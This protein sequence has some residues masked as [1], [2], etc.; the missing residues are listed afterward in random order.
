MN[1][2][3]L[4]VIKVKCMLS[5]V[6]FP[7][8][9]NKL[10]ENEDSTFGIVSW[11]VTDILEGEVSWTSSYYHQITVKGNYY[12]PIDPIKQYIILAKEVENEKYGKEYELLQIILDLELKSVAQQKA[13]L[14]TFLTP[15]QLE[16]MYKIY[17]D[18]MPYIK[19]HDIVAL[20]KIK[21]V[22]EYTAN[23]IIQ[24]Y[25]ENKDNSIIYVE[26][27]DMGLTPNF[28]QKLI[29]KYQDPLK[30]VNIV[31][32]H[33]Y[34]LTYDIEGIG[35]KTAD[36]IALKAGISPTSTERLSAFIKYH[37]EELKDNGYG[38]IT[39]KE[40]IYDIYDEFN[41]KDNIYEEILNDKGEVVDNN[42]NVSLKSLQNNNIIT[43]E[44]NENKGKRRVFLTK[45]YELEKSIAQNLIRLKRSPNIF[46]YSDWMER[47]HKQ[48]KKQGFEFTSEQLDGIKLGLENQVCFITGLAG[49]GKSTLVSGILAALSGYSFSQCA[50][51][52]KAASNLQDVTGEEGKTI[53]RLLEYNPA[54]GFMRNKSNP[55]ME[56]III[57][58]ELSLVGEDIFNILLQAIPNSTK[59][60]LLGDMGQLESIGEGNLAYDIYNSEIIPIVELTKVQR[61]AQK[62]GII[63]IAHEVRHQKELFNINFEGKNTFGELN[64]MHFDVSNTYEDDRE[65]I[66]KYF[67]K[68]YSSNIVKKNIMDI[69]L[70][71]PVKER[72]DTCVFNL[73][74]DV[75]QLINPKKETDK[76]DNIMVINISK[77]KSF[78]IRKKDKVM[79]IKNNY[80]TMTTDGITCP[81]FN[82]WT[83]IV[84][85]INNFGIYVF[86]PLANATVLIERKEVKNELV[87]GYAST[88][89]KIQG[90]SAA[91]VIGVINY[92][93]PPKMLTSQLLYT[94]I[95]RAKKQCVIVGQNKAIN[96]AINTDF[97]SQ[98][99]TFLPEL[100][101]ANEKDFPLDKYKNYDIILNKNNE[102]NDKETNNE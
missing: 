37:L 87:L 6:F 32:K 2:E 24:R 94:L 7:K 42:I 8:D 83:G 15:M 45:Y 16:E 98:K 49:S 20:S 58:D 47:I 55:L 13:F 90:S 27:A 14:S 62:S 70:L 57:L 88:V 67:N 95:T 39:A 89:H 22:K 23:C 12:T 68:L 35:F 77:E 36:K 78:E 61:Q 9:A 1:D 18:P 53:H 80:K 4:K 73:N 93:T 69:Q 75:Q 44:E 46:E 29:K 40:L 52:G 64:D 91:A 66:L 51:S 63:T 65:K 19:N 97:V 54:N 38:Y 101:I 72:G 3:E 41:G 21:G 100:L 43:I 92:S 85:N 48:E 26:L 102:Q 11:E 96:Q 31:K 33:P 30:V 71:S 74:E 10:G 99:R 60:I 82:G 28:I 34:R 84:E 86:F 25:E 59:L 79:C 17:K 50:L 5:R 81:I 56:N 76:D